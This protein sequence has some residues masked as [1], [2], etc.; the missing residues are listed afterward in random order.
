M[1]HRDLINAF[2]PMPEMCQDALMTAANSVQEGEKPMK[3]TFRLAAI[4]AAILL[5]LTSVACA[6]TRPQVL[7]WLLGDSAAGAWLDSAAQTVQGSASADGVNVSVTSL[8][9]DGERLALS[10]E[11]S[12]DDPTSAVFVA[13]DDTIILNGKSASLDTISAADYHMVPSP[14]LDML[15]VKRNPILAG[16]WSGWLPELSGTVDA[17]VTFLISRPE[18]GLIILDE[19]GVLSTDL[20][21]IRD[22]ASRAEEQ[23]RRT[24]ISALTNAMMIQDNPGLWE[25][26]GYTLIDPSGQ[27]ILDNEE[28]NPHLMETRL[29]VRFSFNADKPVVYDFSDVQDS[30]LQD[31]TVRIETFRLSPLATRVLVY[32]VPSEPTEEAARRLSETYGMAILTDERG[33]EVEY[34][35]MDYLSSGIPT[36]VKKGDQWICCYDIDMPEI[37]ALP[38]SIGLTVESSDLVRFDLTIK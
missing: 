38:Q 2:P 35:S 17:E 4:T 24:A 33:N 9:Y 8:V 28:A 21:L 34:A 18:R 13:M 10:Y 23:D 30:A 22:E 3:H 12:V 5:V 27:L 11:A 15:P 25:A 32:L 19:L 14:H 29:T 31:A 20:S 36:V 6:V 16:V 26:D 37:Q 1:N 7:D